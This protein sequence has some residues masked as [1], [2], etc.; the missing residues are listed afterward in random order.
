[1]VRYAGGVP[2]S[3]VDSGGASLTDAD[4]IKYIDFCL[5]DTG[6]MVGHGPLPAAK[7]IAEHAYKGTSFMLPT[8][9]ATW[10]G[11]ELQRRFGLKYWQFATSATDANR[12]AIRLAR[13]ITKRPKVLVFNWCYHG[14]VDETIATLTEDGSVISRKGNIGPQIDPSLTTKVV[15]WNDAEALEE[16]LKDEDVA[17]VM[18][19][20]V[21][22]NI[23]IVHPLPGFHEKMRELTKKYGTYLLIDETHTICT[24]MGGYTKEYNL[25]PDFFIC[26]KTLASGIPVGIYGFT[27]EVGAKA[28][29]ELDALYGL[30]KGIGGTL[31]ANAITMA[32]MRAV[33]EEVLTPEFYERNIPLADRFNEGIHQSIKE[34][35]LPWSTQKLGTRVEY[36]FCEE[37]ATNGTEA[38]N[39]RDFELDWYMHIYALNRG[40][41]MTP[42]HNMAIITTAHTQEDVDKHTE[43]FRAAVAEIVD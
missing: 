31:A 5:G 8:E 22:T 3:V 28:K 1:M 35:N 24:G 32:T 12:F 27:E 23:G 43:I 16:A 40:I 9:D 15:E 4:G 36:W 33:L 21:M 19:E 7:A 14:T 37:E 18:A 42:F 39:S 11:N 41:L 38:V 10:C 20:P 6:S 30:V 25:D 26:G 29:A 13:Q 17:V 2:I 34:F